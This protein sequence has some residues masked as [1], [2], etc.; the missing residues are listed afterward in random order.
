MNEIEQAYG[1]LNILLVFNTG[2]GAV[3]EDDP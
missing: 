1:R 3:A 2:G